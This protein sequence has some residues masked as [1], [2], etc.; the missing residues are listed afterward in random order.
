MGSNKSV[1]ATMRSMPVETSVVAVA[2]LL[3]SSPSKIALNGSTVTVFAIVPTPGG[4]TSETL[5]VDVAAGPIDAMLHVS[6]FDAST[7]QMAGVE[8]T[9]IVP[10]GNGSRTTTLFAMPTPLFPTTYV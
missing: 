1:L 7:L 4:A 10:G 3:V 8:L 6:T 2:V 9:K 5:N